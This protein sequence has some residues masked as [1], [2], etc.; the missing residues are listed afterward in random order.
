M[1]GGPLDV[2]ARNAS[3]DSVPNFGV[4]REDVEQDALIHRLITWRRTFLATS[5]RARRSTRLAGGGGKRCR[6]L[7]AMARLDR[8]HRMRKAAA[9]GHLDYLASNDEQNRVLFS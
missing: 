8:V 7:K 4:G 3:R 2:A 6:I 5:W 1:R 9:V